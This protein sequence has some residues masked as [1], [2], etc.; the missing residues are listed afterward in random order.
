MNAK[1]IGLEEHSLEECNSMISKAIEDGMVQVSYNRYSNRRY[2]K[3]NR[4]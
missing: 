4:L 3:N 1:N 2:K